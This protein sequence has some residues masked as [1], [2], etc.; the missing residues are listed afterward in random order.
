MDA[1]LKE[2]L[3]GLPSFCRLVPLGKY[4]RYKKTSR[5]WVNP[6]R[7]I[8]E[9]WRDKTYTLDK[10]N[11]WKTGIGIVQGKKGKGIVCL[12]FD[13]PNSQPNFKDKLG[14]GLED[15]PPTV[16]WTSGTPHRHQRA[17]IVPESE[18]TRISHIDT[19]PEVEIRW[20]GQSVIAGF[21]RKDPDDEGRNY[22]WLDGCS[23]TEID[24]AIAP[25]MLIAAIENLKAPKVII[26]KSTNKYDEQQLKNHNLARARKG[27][28]QWFKDAKYYVEPSWRKIG[29]CLK[30][31]G[32]DDWGDPDKFFDLWH[33][34]SERDPREGKYDGYQACAEKWEEIEIRDNG[35]TFSSFIYLAIEDGFLTKE[36]L[37]EREKAAIDAMPKKP[38]VDFLETAKGAVEIIEKGWE[39]IATLPR[40]SQRTAALEILQKE[41]GLTPRGFRNV[42]EDLI[43]ESN[44]DNKNY[45]TFEDLM[46][47]EDLKSEALINRLLPK[48]GLVILAAEGGTGKTSFC[49]EIAEAVSNGDKLFG[50]LETVKGNVKIYQCDESPLDATVK[51]EAMTYK[52]N[53]ANLSLHW[54]FK[55]SMI[56]DLEKDFERD[57]TDLCILDSLVKIFGGGNDLNTPEVGLYMYQLNQIASRTK[58][59]ILI[60]H[61]LKKEQKPKGNKSKEIEDFRTSVTKDDLYGNVF[62]FNGA[63]DVW[64][65]WVA[66][67]EMGKKIFSLKN[68]KNRSMSVPSD[69]LYQLK[70]DEETF[71]YSF[72]FKPDGDI[73]DAET[74]E[75]GILI[76][77]ENNIGKKFSKSDLYK[78]IPKIRGILNSKEYMGQVLRD[79]YQDRAKTGIDRCESPESTGGRRPYLYFKR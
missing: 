38:K 54:S 36:D 57:K 59:T 41:A 53:N 73:S 29:I 77:L 47:A 35:T 3:K 22:Q 50:R 27:L 13:G 67:K 61:H 43:A 42:V 66:E 37:T 39:K 9:G 55:P 64:G 20:T 58:T 17:F 49:Y 16:A 46:K 6:K 10:I 2:H 74:M 24:I 19:I 7:P 40:A 63:S 45:S 1:D 76:F 31:L 18:W 11:N 52:P 60:P 70:G 26:S 72:K 25:E 32:N 75:K 23:P 68:L 30:Q 21:H 78:K 48:G 65:F 79:L 44:T 5:H 12:D 33:E 51:F 71:R 56:P 34:W 8:E 15:L 4:E 69:H 14:I 28:T 62:I